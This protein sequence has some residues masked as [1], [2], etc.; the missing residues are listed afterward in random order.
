ML[1]QRNITFWWMND[2][3]K[4]TY[5][6]TSSTNHHSFKASSLDQCHQVTNQ[7]TVKHDD[8]PP[9]SSWV[10]EMKNNKQ[11]CCFCRTTCLIFALY[12]MKQHHFILFYRHFV[13]FCTTGGLTNY[14]KDIMS[15][16][17]IQWWP[18]LYQILL[19]LQF[20]MPCQHIEQTEQLDNQRT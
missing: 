4:H 19:S 8:N 3:H 11:L 16:Y 18:K 7:P 14:V 2:T 13:D 6:Q 17:D 10:M 9:F 15:T 1:Q 5:I 20:S 12:D